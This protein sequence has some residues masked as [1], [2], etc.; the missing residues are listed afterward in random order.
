MPARRRLRISEWD[1]RLLFTEKLAY[2]MKR[3]EESSHCE[4]VSHP[5]EET[6][7]GCD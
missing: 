2:E 7:I 4:A 3:V 6:G 1:A 5:R